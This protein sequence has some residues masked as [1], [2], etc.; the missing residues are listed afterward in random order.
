MLQLPLLPTIQIRSPFQ[1]DR[2]PKGQYRI[3]SANGVSL[4]VRNEGSTGSKRTVRMYFI[5]QDG[6]GQLR[7]LVVGV[8][9]ILT[10]TK[11]ILGNPEAFG[12]TITEWSGN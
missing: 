1:R 2:K 5:V 7:T 8:N 9:N 12:S 3:E 4:V 6:N 10:G 11:G